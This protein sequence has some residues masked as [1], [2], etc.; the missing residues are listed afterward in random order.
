MT[1]GVT[2]LRYMQFRESMST[3]ATRGWRIEGIHLP[4]G[5]YSVPKEMR[6]DTVLKK[7]LR[8][9]IQSR[10]PVAVDLLTKLKELRA[11]LQASHWFNTHEV[12][13]SSLLIVYDSAVPARAPPGVWMIDF[14]NVSKVD[15][16]LQLTHRLPWQ[17]GNREEGY[18][19][20]L[21]D[22]VETFSELSTHSGL[23]ASPSE[24]APML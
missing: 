1:Q 11:A 10:R 6:E 13:S 22:L 7:T 24:A 17:K 21:D 14:A 16:P 4:T 20:G 18:L 15:V 19:F 2:K 3:S 23:V 12:V 9:F 8:A 5:K